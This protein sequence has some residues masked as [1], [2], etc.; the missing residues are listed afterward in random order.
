MPGIES[1]HFLIHSKKCMFC[2]I[3]VYIGKKE[4]QYPYKNI[5]YI[6]CDKEKKNIYYS[7]KEEV[8]NTKRKELAS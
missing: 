4:K 2:T 1:R 8:K 5:I 7:C 3:T 6:Y